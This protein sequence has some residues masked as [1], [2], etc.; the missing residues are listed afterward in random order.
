MMS[1]LLVFAYVGPETVLPVASALAAIGGA[2]MMCGRSVR[3]F[4]IGCVRRVVRR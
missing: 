4:L 1:D 3:S 2:L